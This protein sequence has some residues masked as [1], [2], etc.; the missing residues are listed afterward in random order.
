MRI[1]DRLL[2]CVGFIAHDT[3][4]ITYG[5]TAFV[6]G[7]KSALKGSYL[8][9]V[10]ARHVAEA[11]E[12]GPFIVGLNLKAGGKVMLRSSEG[13]RWW[14]HPSDKSTDVAVMPFAPSMYSDYDIQWISEAYF[15][16][17]QRITKYNIGVGDELTII[18]LFT[19]FSGSTKHF[20]I[21]RIG[22]VAM[23]PTDKIPVKDFGEMEVYLAEGRSIGGLSGSPVFVRNTTSMPPM[24]T[25]DGELRHFSG[26][27][28]M[29]LFGLMHGHWDLPVGF[30]TY[31]QQEAVNMGV[32]IVVPAKIILET[33][34]HPELVEMRN[35]YDEQARKKDY[36]T[37]DSASKN[38]ERKQPIFTKKDFE[39]VLEKAG[40][41]MKPTKIGRAH[42]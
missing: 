29:H 20:P 2:N 33:L 10:T 16:T 15:A 36:P 23:M 30:K 21:V 32:S 17:P 41:K 34:Y 5:G 25:E 13:A 38:S 27:G 3:P 39:A 11:V 1:P 7:I 31:E 40:R 8:H 24:K 37:A 4:Q 22:S 42:V 35:E 28:E 12:H 6:V 9:L 18:G 26:F 19:R 14:Y